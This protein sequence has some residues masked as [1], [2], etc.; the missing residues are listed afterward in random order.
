MAS[1]QESRTITKEK[2]RT[3]YKSHL[4]AKIRIG[5]KRRTMRTGK[6]K[7]RVGSIQPIQ[8]NYS[9]KAKDHV[10]INRRYEQRLGD[11]TEEDALSEGFKDL[12][13]FYEWW[14]HNQGPVVPWRAVTVYDFDYLPPGSKTGKPSPVAELRQ[15]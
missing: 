2:R 15:S 11:M 12:V 9:E 7:Y 5:Q 4:A 1:K 3:L 14:A 10:K 13:A 6:I 8:E